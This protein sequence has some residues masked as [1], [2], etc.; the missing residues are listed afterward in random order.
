LE[1][2]K[3]EADAAGVSNV[4]FQL[5][6]AS[7]IPFLPASFDLVVSRFAVHHFPDPGIELAEMV[8][9]CRPGG[10]VAIMDIL[11]A[12]PELAD[13]YNHRERL[14]D[15]SHTTALTAEQLRTVLGEAGLEIDS[16]TERDQPIPLR[17]W[18]EQSGPPA[19]VAEQ[20]RADL[21][22]ELSDGAPTGMRALREDGE[23]RFTQRW[24]IAVC[25]PLAG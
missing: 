22:R 14:R 12:E 3:R 10:R 1:T 7:T 25:R 21:E 24:A 5:G 18:L 4:L 15:P 23:L 13:E 11:A 19:E 17:R 20:L 9:V 2:G 6:D 16:L 8:R